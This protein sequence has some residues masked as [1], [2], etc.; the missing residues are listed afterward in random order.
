[1][2]YIYGRAQSLVQ[3]GVDLIL[4]PRCSLTGDIVD[5]QGMLSAR[6]WGGLHFV[7]DPYCAHCGVPFE[8]ES[9]ST[10]LDCMDHT[11]PFSMARA[12]L[13]YND[14]SRDLILGFKHG[15]KTHVV[16]SFVPWL[17]KAGAPMWGAADYLIPVPLHA[18]RLI[19]RRYNQA[20]LISGALSAAVGVAHL[21]RA[22]RRIRATASQGHLSTEAR[23]KNVRKAFDIY[24]EFSEILRGKNIVLIDD[25][26]TTGATLR[27]CTQT[28]KQHGAAD[29]RVLTLA[30]VLKS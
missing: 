3:S 24:P 10:C 5:A 26:Y 9:G 7:S 25:V 27:E 4:P 21:P 16:R 14:T 22:M 8:F 28:L 18:R 29:V 12:A 1:M 15:D 6:A 23:A 17:K 30:R 13:V 19:A 2:K 20:A 11:P